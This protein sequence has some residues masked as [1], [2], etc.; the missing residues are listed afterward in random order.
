MIYGDFV[1]HRVSC[2]SSVQVRY[3]LE[4]LKARGIKSVFIDT[5]YLSFK[6]KS[7]LPKCDFSFNKFRKEVLK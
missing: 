5:K 2:D 1:K 4:Q 3:C 6:E 7:L